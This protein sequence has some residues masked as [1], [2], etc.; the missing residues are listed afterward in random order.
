MATMAP[1]RRSTFG[2]KCVRCTDQLIATE[3]SEFRHGTQIR[4]LWYCANYE[5]SFDSVES[6]PV[7][8]MTT[9][10]IFP[11]TLVA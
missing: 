8:A 10:D 4:H 1:N 11:S 6:I 3:R 2:I 5:I 9:D 7:R